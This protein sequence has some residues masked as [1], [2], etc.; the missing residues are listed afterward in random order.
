[1]AWVNSE[2]TKPPST[3]PHPKLNLNMKGLL[4]NCP[5]PGSAWVPFLAQHPPI[6]SMGRG[7]TANH[8]ASQQEATVENTW[9]TADHTRGGH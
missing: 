8:K 6:T 1:M 5:G 3:S 9:S 7:C 4:P 2:D